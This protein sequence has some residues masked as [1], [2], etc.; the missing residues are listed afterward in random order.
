M[1]EDMEILPVQNLGARILIVDDDES[2]TSAVKRCLSMEGY[3]C[4]TA[5]Q[6]QE[7]LDLLEENSYELLISDVLMPGVSG[8]NL[9]AHV[10]EKWPFLPVVMMSG[11]DNREIFVK[12]LQLG[13]YGYITK[14]FSENQL[15]INV[16]NALERGRMDLENI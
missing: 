5:N 6:G 4:F 3:E 14:P 15:L 7:A 8:V 13:A 1:H 10:K 11:L 16:I 2:Y 12:C 9:L